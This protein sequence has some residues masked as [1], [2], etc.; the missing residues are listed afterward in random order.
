MKLTTTEIVAHTDRRGSFVDITD[1][2]RRAIKDSGVIDG[3]ALVFCSHTTCSLIVNEW[4]DG[5]LEDLTSR[6]ERLVPRDHYYA[7][8]DMSR[9][10]QNLQAEER[11]NGRAHVVQMI[12]G[13]TSQ[14]I[15][16]SG[17]EPLLGTWQRLFLAELDEPKPR[18]IVFQVSGL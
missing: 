9:R 4:E 12:M 15:P 5:V 17:G 11:S 10:T 18:R 14:V 2:L 8:D 6:L 13:G 7:H 1:D 16:V 3:T